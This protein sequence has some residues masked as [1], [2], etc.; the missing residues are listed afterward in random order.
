MSHGHFQFN[1]SPL[2]VTVKSPNAVHPCL[3]DPRYSSQ[4]QSLIYLMLDDSE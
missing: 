2:V 4:V 1:S 3:L